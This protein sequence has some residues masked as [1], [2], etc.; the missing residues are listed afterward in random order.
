MRRKRR[1]SGCGFTLVEVLAAGMIL[2]LAA[3]A[4]SLGVR[5]SLRSLQTARDYQ[6]AAELLDRVMTKIDLIGPGNVSAEGPLAGQFD[7]PRERF[8]WESQIELLATEG[9]LYEVTVRIAWPNPAGQKQVVEAQTL[10]FDPP[11][12]DKSGLSWEDV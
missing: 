3:A 11:S 12:Q 7:P 2:A 8:E 5:Q 10:L 9:W 1:Q 6:Q 4:L